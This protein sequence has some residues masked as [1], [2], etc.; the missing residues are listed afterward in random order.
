MTDQP[1]TD[2]LWFWKLLASSN[3][4][5]IALCRQLEQLPKE[6]LRQYRLEYDKRAG[7]VNPHSW[8]EC[9]PHYNKYYSEDSSEDFAVW[10]V[11]QGLD[12]YDEV[13]YHPE[14]ID[15]YINA[16]EQ[17]EV[18]RRKGDPRWWNNDVDRPEYRGYQRADY[19]ASPIYRAR[20]GE[21]L[22]EACYDSRGWPREAPAQ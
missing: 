6:Q 8:E 19:V 7:Y 13:A 20:F 1:K 15:D 21:D 5:L 2:P 11:M 3:R 9:Q 18:E 12:F 14:K 4:N 17:A 16:Y 10:V 22:H